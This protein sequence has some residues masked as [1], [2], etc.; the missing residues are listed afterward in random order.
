MNYEI[1]KTRFDGIK[2]AELHLY[3][4]TGNERSIASDGDVCMIS[5]HVHCT[6]TWL[7]EYWAQ[8]NRR[9]NQGHND[10]I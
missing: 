4:A 2:L 1:C 3:S 6:S 9:P 5:I 10:Y 8:I 7:Y